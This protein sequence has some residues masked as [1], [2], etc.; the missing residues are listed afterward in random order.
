LAEACGVAERILD[1]WFDGHSVP[2]DID[3]LMTVVDSLARWAG[4]PAPQH[5]R[6]ADLYAAAGESASEA[7]TN[8]SG[9]NGPAKDRWWKKPAVWIA[10]IVAS[11]LAA[12]LASSLTSGL[13]HLTAAG[14]K[15]SGIPF[16]WTIART[17]G[18][19][20]SCEGWVFRRPINSIPP[21]AFG[22]A[23]ADERWALRNHGTDIGNAV[24]TITLQGTT[25]EAVV[26]QD[27]RIRM[28]GKRSALCA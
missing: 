22:N 28:V 19:L 15:S 1:T 10:G 13:H 17:G 14:H 12:I 23:N 20:N 21:R 27:I 5:G 2:R 8:P 9:G 11:A 25:S 16:E 18:V 7:A 6:W 26:I 4:E 3:Q 24:W